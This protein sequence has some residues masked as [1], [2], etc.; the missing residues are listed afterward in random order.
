[1]QYWDLNSDIASD[2]LKSYIFYF[3]NKI[4]IPFF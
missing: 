1:M 2:Q 3:G 4:L